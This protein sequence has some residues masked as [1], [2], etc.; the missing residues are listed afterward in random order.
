LEGS[1]DVDVRIG[2]ESSEFGRGPE[3]VFGVG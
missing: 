1:D 2:V 3:G